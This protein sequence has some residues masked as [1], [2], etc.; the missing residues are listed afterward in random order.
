MYKTTQERTGKKVSPKLKKLIG[1]V[2]LPKDFDEKEELRSYYEKNHFDKSAYYTMNEIE[3][4][5]QQFPDNVQEI[6]QNIRKLVKDNAPGAEESFAYGMPAY[7]TNKKPLVYFAAFKTH[8]GLY[9]TPSGHRAFQDELSKYKQGKGSVQ[10][11]INKPIPYK[12]IERIV[13]FRVTENNQRAS[14]PA[15]K[16]TKR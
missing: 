12:L 5:I 7:K 6:L 10:F 15:K 11:P 8:I 3:T 14:K 16:T 13:K 9:A 2:K 4:Y 1:A